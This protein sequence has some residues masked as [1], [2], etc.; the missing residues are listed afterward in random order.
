[1]TVISCEMNL[2]REHVNLCVSQII[3]SFFSL[4]I[5]ISSV[6]FDMSSVLLVSHSQSLLR[7]CQSYK[8]S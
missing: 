6:E 4:L 1:M 8:T 7:L 5:V 2:Q 3:P